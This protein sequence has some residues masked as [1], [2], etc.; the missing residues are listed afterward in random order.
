M[1]PRLTRPWRTLLPLL[2][3]LACGP[4]QH[5]PPELVPLSTASF[6][7]IA[8][9][10][11][12]IAVFEVTY[13]ASEAVWIRPDIEALVP[14]KERRGAQSFREARNLMLTIYDHAANHYYVAMEAAIDAD[15]TPP[16]W[17]AF[18]FGFNPS[19]AATVDGVGGHLSY[20]ERL[21]SDDR[22]VIWRGPDGRPE[23]AEILLSV[24][25]HLDQD[26][27]R[28]VNDH[29]SI[30]ILSQEG[31]LH[32]CDYKDYSNPNLDR[33]PHAWGHEFSCAPVA[34]P[35]QAPLP[36]VGVCVE[37]GEPWQS[38]LDR[39]EAAKVQQLNEL[40]LLFNCDQIGFDQPA[41]DATDWHALERP[42]IDVPT[43]CSPF[44]DWDLFS[45]STH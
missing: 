1:T 38:V 17:T 32:R 15:E 21:Q 27:S 42:K 30:N 25:I 20:W 26:L 6:G 40:V 31:A 39:L 44:D 11:D 19:P 33:G 22:F 2:A 29:Q 35:S 24:D 34:D 5:A 8:V 16:S 4:E 13:S 37:D 45:S 28:F 36:R 9:H 7:G 41:C 10:P 43:T 18:A 14:E 3:L 23:L 12:L